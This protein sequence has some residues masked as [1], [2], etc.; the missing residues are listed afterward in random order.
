MNV[1]SRRRVFI[2]EDEALIA[3][4]LEDRL[5]QFG[6]EVCG[7]AARGDQALAQ[8][9]E[10]APDVVVMDVNLGGGLSGF[11]VA[12]QLAAVCDVPVVFLTAYSEAEFSERAGGRAPLY[13]LKPFQPG[14]LRAAL[15]RALGA[16]PA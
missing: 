2:V 3:M 14:A 5:Q 1:M 12:D 7:R 9:P 6:F 8:I 11:E 4:E 10:A 16:R 15:E 13:V